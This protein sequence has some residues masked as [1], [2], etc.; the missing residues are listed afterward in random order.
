VVANEVRQLG[1]HISLNTTIGKGTRF[2]VRL[3]LTLAVMQVLIVRAG[4]QRFALPVVSVA[5]VYKRQAEEID[6]V[7]A[8]EDHEINLGNRTLPYLDLNRRLGFPAPP[9]NDER[10][11]VLVIRV[12]DREVALGVETLVNRQE[13]V[14]KPLGPQLAS[15]PGIGGATILGDGSVVLILEP[16]E[17]WLRKERSGLA[18]TV[19]ER[20]QEEKRPRVMVVD[21]SLTVRKITDRQLRRQGIDVLLA[22]DGVDAVEQ[23]Q[24]TVP[25]V[26]LVDIEMPRMDGF[27]LIQRVRADSRTRHVPIIVITSR[28]GSK[29]RDRAMQL[30]AD[31]YLSKPYRDDDL[32]GN[33]ESLI[34]QNR[35]AET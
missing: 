22:K 28:A 17:L 4:P 2:S 27:E 15:V 9:G 18:S 32:L 26:M 19:V 34:A 14:V 7:M 21:D 29:H 35:R 24:E 12:G 23:L 6:R 30:G 31:V 11:S 10:V 1:G 13:I 16:S 33:V 20:V 8:S 3:P 25:D 5:T